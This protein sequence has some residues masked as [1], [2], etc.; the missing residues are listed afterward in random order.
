METISPSQ[1]IQRRNKTRR[2]YRNRKGERSHKTQ[3]A[4]EYINDV[5]PSYQEYQTQHTGKTERH[6][7]NYPPAFNPNIG[8]KVRDK[9]VLNAPTHIQ[10][11]HQRQGT[12][13]EQEHSNHN[14]QQWMLG[15]PSI[16]L[17]PFVPQYFTYIL[18][19]S[20]LYTPIIPPVLLVTLACL[21]VK[22][23][24]VYWFHHHICWGFS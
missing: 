3:Q 10:K 4:I 22:S 11:K 20:S 7:N 13:I 14:N 17:F 23:Q 18:R 2:T 5:F 15:C 12:H 9:N 19:I 16:P 8:V 24:F 21:L 6:L 1:Q